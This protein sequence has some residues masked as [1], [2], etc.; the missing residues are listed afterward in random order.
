MNS[1]MIPRSIF[2][3]VSLGKKYYEERFPEDYSTMEDNPNYTSSGCGIS[4]TATAEDQTLSIK[5]PNDNT[6]ELCKMIYSNKHVKFVYPKYDMVDNV[7]KV[8]IG[9]TEKLNILN[10]NYSKLL[11]MIDNSDRF[12]YVVRVNIEGCD[13]TTSGGKYG[14]DVDVNTVSV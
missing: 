4:V 12:K 9:S 14:V 10:A 6:K 2:D 1:I 7:V 13:F 3:G 8:G 5:D 11:D